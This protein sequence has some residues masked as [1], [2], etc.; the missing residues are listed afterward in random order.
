VS[1]NVW[2]QVADDCLVKRTFLSTYAGVSLAATLI[3]GVVVGRSLTSQVESEARTVALEQA[4]LVRDLSVTPLLDGNAYM[5]GASVEQQKNL[6]AL[7]HA[8]GGPSSLK[9]VVIRNLNGMEIYSSFVSDSK[10]VLRNPSSTSVSRWVTSAKPVGSGAPGRY[11]FVSLPLRAGVDDEIVGVFETYI[12]SGPI[13]AR[14]AASQRRILFI[15]LSALLLLW[16]VLFRLVAGVSRRLRD[17]LLENRH[18]AKH[19]QLTGLPN[20]LLFEEL[21]KPAIERCIARKEIG[22]ILLVDLDRFKEVNDTL[23]HGNGDRLLQQIGPRLQTALR[24]HDV[25][26]R[27]GGDEFVILLRGLRKPEEADDVA[28]RLGEALQEPFVIADI[29]LSIEASFGVAVAPGDGRSYQSLLQKADVAMYRAK[30]RRS[31]VQHYDASFDRRSSDRLTMLADLRK[32]IEE[33]ALT[34]VYQPKIDLHTNAVVGTEALLRWDHPTRGIVSPGE[35]IPLAEGSGLVRPLTKMVLQQATKDAGAWRALGLTFG[36]SVNVSAHNLLDDALHD[37][38]AD[39]LSASGMSPDDLTLEITETSVMLD[40]EKSIAT[41]TK[42]RS[43]GIGVSVDDFGIGQS[44][45]AYLKRFPV[46]ELKL[47]RYFVSRIVTDETDRAIVRAALDLGVALG[48]S[49]VA[50][51]IE[52]QAEA[53]C[54]RALGCHYAQGFFFAKP[55]RADDLIAFAIERAAQS[56]V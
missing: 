48:L 41:L 32:A 44:S 8:A 54:L 49:V 20:R 13:S 9:N 1:L 16:A 25:L 47:D 39:A 4:V 40:P 22:G 3:I 17:Q 31:G 26:A 35:F 23:G 50:E 52:T 11:L 19:D 38:V 28:R 29:P 24:P 56:L 42:L 2:V 6:R 33:G 7:T 21:A 34:L 46:T 10:G 15:L 37:H 53:D 36:V 5:N 55:M 12:E 18:L 45:L 51:G 14:L 27:L 30:A 43:H